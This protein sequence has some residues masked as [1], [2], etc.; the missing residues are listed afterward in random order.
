MCTGDANPAVRSLAAQPGCMVKA[1]VD[2]Q[3]L[4]RPGMTPLLKP[5]RGW[6]WKA[7][8][9]C[10]ALEK[11]TLFAFE[12]LILNITNAPLRHGTC[13]EVKCSG[14][15]SLQH[16]LLPSWRGTSKVVDGVFFVQKTGLRRAAGGLSQPRGG[17]RL[18]KPRSTRKAS[19]RVPLGVSLAL[20]RI[21]KQLAKTEVRDTPRT[22]TLDFRSLPGSGHG[23]PRLKRKTSVS[24]APTHQVDV[25]ALRVLANRSLL[26]PVLK[27]GENLR[28]HPGAGS[29]SAQPRGAA[30]LRSEGRSGETRGTPSLTEQRLSPAKITGALPF[31]ASVTQKKKKLKK[32]N[33]GADTSEARK[34]RMSDSFQ[35]ETKRKALLAATKSSGCCHRMPG[36]SIHERAALAL[37]SS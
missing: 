7:K 5:L 32:S 10:S 6:R 1:R 15:S 9:L 23:A 12:P 16:S 30:G 21:R 17:R 25:G 27:A 13:I 2:G 31:S 20:P 29:R 37:A 14:R 3:V 22:R 19:R 18:Q 35:K 4:G 26:S 11:G 33:F 34:H 28:I 36:V 8:L 24:S